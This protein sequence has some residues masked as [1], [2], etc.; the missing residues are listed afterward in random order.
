M[1]GSSS[2][3]AAVRHGLAVPGAVPKSVA[4]RA[5]ARVETEPRQRRHRSVEGHAPPCAPAAA[6]APIPTRS[7]EARASVSRMRAHPD[8]ARGRLAQYRVELGA[9]FASSDGIDRHERAVDPKQPVSCR[10][11]SLNVVHD[12]SES[13]PAKIK[14]SNTGRSRS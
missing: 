13:M 9:V 12:G 14:A 2:G 5:T 8:P 11:E 10:V 1:P 7:R 6:S 4:R 3:R